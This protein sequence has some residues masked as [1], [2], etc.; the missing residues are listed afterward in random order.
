M[1]LS[2][3]S[4]LRIKALVG[5]SSVRFEELVGKTVAFSE[6]LTQLR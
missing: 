3:V 4:S 2:H 1:A 5:V 6:A